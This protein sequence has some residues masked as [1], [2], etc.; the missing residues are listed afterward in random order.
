[1]TYYIW[2][3]QQ[4]RP[5][6]YLTE[7]KEQSIQDVIKSLLTTIDNKNWMI[8]LPKALWIDRCIGCNGPREQCPTLQ[9]HP[10]DCMGPPGRVMLV[11]TYNCYRCNKPRKECDHFQAHQCDH[12]GFTNINHQLIKYTF[13][14]TTWEKR[15]FDAIQHH[16]F[17][18]KHLPFV[19]SHD[20]KNWANS[21]Q[22]ILLVSND[23]C[24][25]CKLPRQQC[26]RFLA[27]N[28]D[29]FGFTQP[30]QFKKAYTKQG[31]LNWYLLPNLPKVVFPKEN[32]CHV[33]RRS[34]QDGGWDHEASQQDNYE[35]RYS[36]Y[37]QVGDYTFYCARPD[38]KC[39]C[40]QDR[41]DCPNF[42][43]YGNDC[44]GFSSIY[45]HD[46]YQDDYY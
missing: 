13:T 26:S 1:M 34:P 9:K 28:L 20:G 22:F 8:V 2:F 37:Y 5:I 27:C 15:L 11:S 24:Y 35:P 3:C 21:R 46:A 7:L 41:K 4:D 40:G 23:T 43:H 19:F 33:V 17:Q 45:E 10:Y 29:H 42:Q 12:D 39:Y 18:S 25:G 16:P 38:G 36:Y 32:I 31:W 30:M 14:K 44:Q 6:D